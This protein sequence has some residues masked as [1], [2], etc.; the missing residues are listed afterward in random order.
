M[1]VLFW[2]SV[3]GYSIMIKDLLG[4]VFDK[5]TYWLLMSFYKDLEATEKG[6]KIIQRN[7]KPAINKADIV[8][9]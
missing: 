1:E 9:E 4:I 6:E 5:L 7:G 2:V 8:G 3:K